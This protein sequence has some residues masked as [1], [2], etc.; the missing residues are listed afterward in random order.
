MTSVPT[1][2]KQLKVRNLRK[3]Y[4]GS[5]A[6]D[7]ISF[8]VAHGECLA[9]LGPSGCGKTTTLNMLAGFVI[10]DGGSVSVGGDDITHR[11]PNKRNIGMVFQS[12]ALFPHLTAL[13]NVAY[14]LKMRGVAKAERRERAM[15]GLGLVQ[16]DH[17]AKR[18]PRQLSGGQQQ[19]IAL[20][21]ALVI[22]PDVLLLDEPLSNLDAKLREAMR[23]EIKDIQQ[24]QQVTTVFVTH[25]QEEAMTLAD[26]VAV[27]DSGR[28]VQLAAPGDL[29]SRPATVGVARFV[30]KGS[31][32]PAT[33]VGGAGEAPVVRAD[34]IGWT[35]EA[36]AAESLP[37]GTGVTLVLR[38]EA[39]QLSPDAPGAEGI[40]GRVTRAIFNGS[41]V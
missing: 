16:L 33:V 21:R 39:L 14:G 10:S 13:D 41:H 27:M 38:P 34:Q 4:A 17:L 37:A 2:A 31:F 23:V 35:G 19:R 26:R 5:T 9:L 7:G 15:T 25:D 3:E 22:N 32:V 30:G 11:A 20:A 28:I 1:Q 8:D 6:V 18:Y 29:Y 24:R 36:I 40:E 12:Y